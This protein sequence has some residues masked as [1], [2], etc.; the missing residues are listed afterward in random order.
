[1]MRAPPLNAIR[2]R[3][4]L[5]GHRWDDTA[6]HWNLVGIRALGRLSD[7]WQ[8][9]ILGVG[10][11][12]EGLV[13]VGGPGTTSPGRPGLVAPT[14]P[15]GTAVMLPGQYVD[16]YRVGPGAIHGRTGTSPYLAFEQISDADYIRDRDRDEI[17]D[18]GTTG[19]ATSAEHFQNLRK[20]LMLDGRYQR[21]NIKSNLHR[22]SRVNGK[23]VPVVGP[24]SLACQV[25]Q[26]VGNFDALRNAFTGA[27]P[28][29]GDR[30]T[31]T[32]LDQWWDLPEG[33]A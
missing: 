19:Y 3:A 2:A 7:L 11:S 6:M 9:T 27:I 20:A 26:L 23:L 15:R 33:P 16:L 32:L 30:V 14:N 13:Y 10:N 24:Y 4:L 21:G 29:Q 17:I 1:M 22:A 28:L 31:Y 12:P 18:I 5:L 25:V 8:D